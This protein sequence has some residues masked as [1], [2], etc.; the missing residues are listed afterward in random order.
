LT[1]PNS[2]HGGTTGPGP[3]LRR[4]TCFVDAD[5]VQISYGKVTDGHW[6]VRATS[7]RW[8]THIERHRDIE[9]AC[10]ALITWLIA[11]DVWVPFT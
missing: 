3:N 8:G 4:L 9:A 6:E 2:K 1:D 11:A 5:D 10:A 7:R